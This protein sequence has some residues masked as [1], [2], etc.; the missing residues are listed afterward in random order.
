MKALYFSAAMIF[1]AAFGAL[2]YRAAER[3]NGTDFGLL[4]VT[5]VCLVTLALTWKH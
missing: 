1:A 4:A 2:A 3:R 5:W